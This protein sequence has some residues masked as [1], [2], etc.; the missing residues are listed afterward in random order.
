[1]PT[2]TNTAAS[3]G[4]QEA[5]VAVE[6]LRPYYKHFADTAEWD[7]VSLAAPDQL[8]YV[9]SVD[10]K[11]AESQTVW[12]SSDAANA[13][14]AL[15]RGSQLVCTS[16]PVPHKLPSALVFRAG[17]DPAQFTV[18]TAPAAKL[19]L[20]TVDVSNCDVPGEWGGGGVLC[21]MLALATL[22]A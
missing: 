16:K 10:C 12:N 20:V 13:S 6:V 21:H 4:T 15:A 5:P 7:L 8:E 22:A 19:L 11:T 2:V 14:L 3:T 18:L 1:M 9:P 17:Q